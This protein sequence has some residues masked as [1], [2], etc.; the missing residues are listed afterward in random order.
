MAPVVEQ[1]TA[2]YLWYQPVVS[3]AADV[4]DFVD[5][6]ICG[7]CAAAGLAYKVLL[8][9]VLIVWLLEQLNVKNVLIRLLLGR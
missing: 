3:S 6:S 8:V 7:V 2:K 1:K 5:Q 4:F 9:Y